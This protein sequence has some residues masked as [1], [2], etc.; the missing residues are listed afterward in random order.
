MGLAVPINLEANTY[1]KEVFTVLVQLTTC[2]VIKNNNKAKI[3]TQ[4]V[5]E[6]I[7]TLPF[8]DSVK[9]KRHLSVGE[10]LLVQIAAVPSDKCGH[11]IA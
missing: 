11:V 4:A 1:K 3:F 5:G 2:D 8:F 7:E 6:K 9:V 10:G